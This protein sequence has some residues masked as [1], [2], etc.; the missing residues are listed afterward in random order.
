MAGGRKR[1][2]ARHLVAIGQRLLGG[3]ALAQDL[4]YVDV[5]E[6][7]WVRCDTALR[8][9]LDDKVDLCCRPTPDRDQGAQAWKIAM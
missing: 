9:Q 7:C 6:S 3:G 4:T 5:H 8:F 2:I 1:V